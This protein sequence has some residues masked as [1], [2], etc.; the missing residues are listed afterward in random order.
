MSGLLDANDKSLTSLRRFIS[1]R[2]SW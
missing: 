1:S 2:T